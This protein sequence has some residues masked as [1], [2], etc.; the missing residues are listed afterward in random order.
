VLWGEVWA[1]PEADL[2]P[3]EIL[4]DE[5][6]GDSQRRIET[7]ALKLPDHGARGA[8]DSRWRQSQERRADRVES[9]PRRTPIH[10]QMDLISPSPRDT[11]PPTHENGPLCETTQ[12]RSVEPVVL[13]LSRACA[14]R[15]KISTPRP[16]QAISS[17]RRRAAWPRPRGNS[18][19]RIPS[20]EW[21]V[22]TPCT[23]ASRIARGPRDAVRIRLD[24][25]LWCVASGSMR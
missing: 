18:S 11:E 1:I 21:D 12:S 13:C 16:A 22:R 9:R 7:P 20:A 24:E 5:P 8:I 17:V 4:S 14:Q 23:T 3:P 10:E 6:G 25:L 15:A 2:R 19:S